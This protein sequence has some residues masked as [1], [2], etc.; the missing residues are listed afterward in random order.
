MGN[1]GLALNDE[2]HYPEAEKVFRETLAIKTKK[3]GAEHRSTLVTAGNLANVLRHEGKY[4]EAEQLI[5]QTLAIEE[6]TLGKD[7][8]DTLVSKAVLGQVLGEEGHYPEAERV[9]REDYDSLLRVVGKDHPYTAQSAY[10]LAVL[11]AAEGKKA[12]AVT[13]L[14]APSTMGC[15]APRILAWAR[16]LPETIAWRSCLRGVSGARPRACQDRSERKTRFLARSEPPARINSST[17]ST[18]YS[19]LGQNSLSFQAS[20]QIVRAIRSPLSR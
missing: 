13:M 16:S 19:R 4:A 6:R 5:R 20:S 11:Y 18:L 9:L 14:T 8:T 1:L 7:H 15:R 2:E 12:E 10:D 3:L 17:G